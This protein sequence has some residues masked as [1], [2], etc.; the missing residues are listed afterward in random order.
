MSIQQELLSMHSYLMYKKFPY[1]SVSVIH[2]NQDLGFHVIFTKNVKEM[3]TDEIRDYL[4][5]FGFG[6]SYI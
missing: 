6:L 4:K 1:H 3:V 2:R 5:S